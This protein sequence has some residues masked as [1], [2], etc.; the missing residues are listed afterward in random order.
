MEF[1]ILGFEVSS[2]KL[3][4]WATIGATILAGVLIALI[5]RYVLRRSVSKKFPQYIYIPLERLIFYAI[6]IVVTI[7]ALRPLGL[8]LS[9]LLIAG[10]IIGIAVGFASQTVVA[11]MLSGIFLFI[12]RPLKIGDPVRVEGIEG[13]VVD[14]SVFSTKIRAWD[15]YI[16]RIPND[17]V[18]G[19]IITNFE[20]TPVRR[21]AFKIGISYSSDVEKARKAILKAMEEHPFALVEPAPEVYVD[22]FGENAIIL[23]ARCWA[24]APVWFATKKDLLEAIKNEL[25]RA[26]IEIPFPQR[27]VWLPKDLKVRLER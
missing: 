25:T 13:R 6:I 15:G 27:V 10:G 18:F 26:G 14:I 8:D 5:I 17:K 7:A 24:P 1:N 20:R 21:I 11:N 23:S 22:D 4:E 3:Y 19:S 9:G 12:D 16:V 2:E